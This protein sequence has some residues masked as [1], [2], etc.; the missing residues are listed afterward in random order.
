V[1]A[2]GGTQFELGINY[3]LWEGNWWFGVNDNHSTWTWLGYYPGSLFAPTGLGS[4]AQWLAW[5]GEV[6]SGLATPVRRRTRRAPAATRR[7]AGRTRPTSG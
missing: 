1:S 3:R 2:A 5:G 4:H 7:A 6:F